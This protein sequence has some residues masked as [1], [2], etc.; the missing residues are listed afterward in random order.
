M[1]RLVLVIAGA[2]SLTPGNAQAQETRAELLAQMREQKAKSLQPYTPKGAEKVLLYVEENRILE[3]LTVADGFYPR[4]VRTGRH[5]RY[6]QR[7][8]PGH[9]QSA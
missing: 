2:L 1:L 9:R 7:H 6:L 4:I 3:R 5:W 8:Q